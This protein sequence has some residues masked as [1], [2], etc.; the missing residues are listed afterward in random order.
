MPGCKGAKV[1]LAL[2]RA[3]DL[4]KHL[5]RLSVVVVAALL[6]GAIGSAQSL[7][8]TGVPLTDDGLLTAASA[9]RNLRSYMKR[10]LQP[11]A[12]PRQS[13]MPSFAALSAADLNNLVA[14]LSAL[15]AEP[16]RA[17]PTRGLDVETWTFDRLDNIGGHPTTVQGEPRVID[18]PLG[19]AVEFDGTDDALFIEHHP[20]AGA[21]TF[22]LEAI[23]RPDGGEKE[24]RWLHL[25]EHPATG[26]DSENRIL[27][28][29]R[30]VDDQWYFDSY[31]QSGAASK[32]LINRAALHSLGA[33]YH[34][35]AVYDGKEFSNYVNGVREGAAELSLAPHGPGRASVGVRINKVFYFKGAVHLA[36]FTRRALA[37][38]AFLTLAR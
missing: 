37:P 36:R 31:A 38:S 16:P 28:E 35:A 25:N 6:L 27:F 13:M 18:S 7:S 30:V 11:L 5:T 20:L 33:W 34:V 26:A 4:V 12:L 9:R 23:F 22:T 29:I 21:T 1:A 3:I 2:C 19:K 24:Q 15:G 32:A 10:D 14:H 17:T 8:S